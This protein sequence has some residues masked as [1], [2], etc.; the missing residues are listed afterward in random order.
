MSHEEVTS[1]SHRKGLSG[2]LVS[3]PKCISVGLFIATA[4]TGAVLQ[5]SVDTLHM[6]NS[7]LN[8]VEAYISQINCLWAGNPKYCKPNGLFCAIIWTR[9]TG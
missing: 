4:S 6:Y 8:Y 5:A 7:P 1:F 9:T 3:R 2:S